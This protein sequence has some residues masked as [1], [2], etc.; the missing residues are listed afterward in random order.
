MRQNKQQKVATLPV[1]VLRGLL[2]GFALIL[3]LLAVA[4]FLVSGGKIAE[5]AMRHV[6]CVCAFAG[7]MTGSLIAAGSY[8]RRRFLVGAGLGIVMFLVCFVLAA[9]LPV[10]KFPSQWHAV[11]LAVFTL[12]GVLGGVISARVPSRRH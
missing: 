7:S 12:G 5:Y 11:L 2:A 4:T 8:A 10:A 6:T 1:A 3:I 9:V